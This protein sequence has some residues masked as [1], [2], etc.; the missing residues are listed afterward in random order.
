[1]I[2][3]G[4]KRGATAAALVARRSRDPPK[5]HEL[6]RTLAQSGLNSSYP[7]MDLIWNNIMSFARQM[8]KFSLTNEKKTE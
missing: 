2:S 6:S 3:D 1:M 8:A 5:C 7:E 4:G